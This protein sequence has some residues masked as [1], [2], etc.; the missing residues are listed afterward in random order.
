[1]SLEKEICDLFNQVMKQEDQE[2][3]L[4][5]PLKEYG[6]DSV[7]AVKLLSNLEVHFDIDISEERAQT[8]RCLQ[9]VIDIV[10]ELKSAG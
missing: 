3:D 7:K 10:K 1:M 2:V 8:I 5:R 9:D 4:Q 6:V